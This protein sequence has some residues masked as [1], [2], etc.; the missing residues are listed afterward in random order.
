MVLDSASFTTQYYK[1]K[2][3]EKRAFES[4][5]TTVVKFTFTYIY[6]YI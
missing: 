5:S 4:P 2:A 3:N 1:V 6:I